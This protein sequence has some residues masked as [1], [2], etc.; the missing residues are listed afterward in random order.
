M[1]ENTYCQ[2]DSKKRTK[3]NSRQ[4]TLHGLS[5]VFAYIGLYAA[6]LEQDYVKHCLLF[7]DMPL[8]YIIKKDIKFFDVNFLSRKLTKTSIQLNTCGVEHGGFAE[9]GAHAFCTGLN[10]AAAEFFALVGIHIKR[11]A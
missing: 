5:A 6:V 7:D 4:S 9:R 2:N 3:N 1:L 8:W 11:A 10:L